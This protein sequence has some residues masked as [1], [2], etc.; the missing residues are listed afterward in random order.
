MSTGIS[1]HDV[2]SVEFIT[3]FYNHKPNNFHTKTLFIETNDGGN[4]EI[5]LFSDEFIN[6]KARDME[7]TYNAF[8]GIEG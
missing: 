6:M 2:K 7:I 1:I 3:K 4:Y 5:T 8:G